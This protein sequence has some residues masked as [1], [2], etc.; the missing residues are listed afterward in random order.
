[1]EYFPG[2][3]SA[4]PDW[5]M[6]SDVARQVY[7]HVPSIGET[8]GVLYADPTALA[9]LLQLTGPVQVPGL[10]AAIDS[11]NVEEYLFVGQYVQYD[12]DRRPA[13][14]RAGRRDP[15]RFRSPHQPTPAGLR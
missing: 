11:T 13:P 6:D 4:S 14:R 1:M 8:D 10:D 9:A 15:F 5:P 7:A 3:V 12:T 2:N